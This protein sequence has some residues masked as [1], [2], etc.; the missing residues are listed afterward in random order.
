MRTLVQSLA[1]LSGLRVWRCHELWCRSQTW[2]RSLVAVALAV[3][4]SY[5]SDSTPSLGISICR[6]CGPKKTKKKKKKTSHEIIL[7]IILWRKSFG[8]ITFF[9]FQLKYKE[10]KNYTDTDMESLSLYLTFQSFWSN[11]KEMIK[12]TGDNI[13]INK[14]VTYNVND[15]NS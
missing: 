10:W 9:F 14:A 13:S 6:G 5:S 4:G 12:T 7:L 11:V 8:N 3:A 2:L 1:L 15:F